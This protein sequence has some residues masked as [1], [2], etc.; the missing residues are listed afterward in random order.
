MNRNVARL[1]MYLGPL[2]AFGVPGAACLTRPVETWQPTL[3]TPFTSTLRSEA[4]DKL[5]VLFMID[6]SA[7]MGDKQ[8]LLAQAVPD[9][10]SR[11]VSPNCVDTKGNT[12]GPSTDGHCTAG[13]LE[14]P[15][16]H[17]MHLGIVSSSL[18]AR[19]GDVCD[20]ANVNPANRSLNAHQD[21]R[22]ELVARG[23]VAEASVA[24]AGSLNFLAWFPT[25]AA[26]Q[27]A[28]TPPVPAETVIGAPGQAGTLIGDFASMIQGVNEHGCGYEAQN[29]AWYRFL[30]Q[31][32]PYDSITV[33]ADDSAS[34]TGI[35]SVLLQQ[36]AAFL[37]PD[38]LLAIIV[39][40]DENEQV[41]NPLAVGKQ[42]WAFETYPFKS[43]PA[44]AGAPEGTAA[45]G[46]FSA[47]PG[48]NPG[49]N[50]AACTSCGFSGVQHSPTFAQEC[51]ADPPNG[52]MGFLDPTDD[53]ILLRFF[54]EK[55]R[56]GVTARYPIS[57]YVN[58]LTHA[59]VPSQDHETDGAGN[60]VGDQSQYQN[61]INPIFAQNLPTSSTAD[62]CNLTRGPR[63]PDQV[64]YAAIA[65]VPHQLLQ[66]SPGDPECPAGTNA[67]DCQQKDQISDA[68]W[69]K[70]IG[71]DPV[72]YDFTG[73][74][75][76]M[77][78]SAV[79]RIGSSCPPASNDDCDPVNGREWDSK[80]QDL[81]YACIF[82]LVDPQTGAPQPKDCTQ[83]MYSGACDCA[84]GSYDNGAPLCQKDATGAYTQV[85][86][87][88]KAYPSAREMQ[89]A[90]A[91]GTQGI[92]SSLCPI[93][94]VA[95]SA[96]DPVFGYRPAVNAI[97][98]RLKNALSVQ[99]LPQKLNVD[100]ATQ[101][102]PCLILVTLAEGNCNMVPGMSD[103]P[104]D[105]LSRFQEAQRS[106]HLAACGGETSCAP[107]DPS[108]LPTCQLQELTP[109]THDG[110]DFQGG[111]CSGST[112]PGWCYV[113]GAAAG[114]C[115]QQILFTAGEPPHGATVT[116]QCLEGSAAG[117]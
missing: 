88:G 56:F 109:T 5:D 81:Q 34:V 77:L 95:S 12:I 96:T 26:N 75:F 84:A 93:H 10:I 80:K 54:D 108:T 46:S 76:H 116:L 64:F 33:G 41:S 63:T 94:A 61:C 49:P 15:P 60:Y 82:P 104:A 65:G 90:H 19:G 53:G 85:Q 29:E 59:T 51:P 113:E 105:V 99:C 8:A 92:V 58:A 30:V 87:N 91:V 1:L 32:D 6:N 35:D 22:G 107:P 31:P 14:F 39:V 20:P 45:C 36:R 38:S 98:N 43:A 68:D 18:G 89:I 86:I 11:L 100:P 72:N 106:A 69:T 44:N 13:K 114:S 37:R 27:G 25:V 112:N 66:A 117:M 3:V 97:V 4:V 79:P 110:A 55:Q 48:P 62:L 47:T 73:M 7:S 57:R 50:S 16:V 83:P 74:D 71:T 2:V 52:T 23:G 40:T 78:E 17:D 42:A 67:A 21:D 101:T 111:D 70:I 24:N 103:P 115:S 28:A 9:M 102:V